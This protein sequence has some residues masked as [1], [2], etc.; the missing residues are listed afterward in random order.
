MTAQDKELEQ[1]HDDI[2]EDVEGL[3]EKYMSIV[4][5]DVPENDEPEARKKI[6]NIIKETIKKIENEK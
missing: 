6:F 5:W 1:L 3:I 2:V 4:G